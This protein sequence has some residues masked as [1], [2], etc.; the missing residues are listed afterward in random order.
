MMGKNLLCNGR[1]LVLRN[2]TMLKLSFLT[3]HDGQAGAGGG[4]GLHD[5]AALH[6]DYQKL[7]PRPRVS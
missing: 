5:G 6:P 4:A 1:M 2:S 3:G 7:P